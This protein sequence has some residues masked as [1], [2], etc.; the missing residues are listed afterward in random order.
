[1]LWPRGPLRVTDDFFYIYIAYFD[2]RPKW[3]P[4][5]QV[6]NTDMHHRSSQTIL[7][8]KQQN[9]SQVYRP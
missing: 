7:S 2:C 5:K 8:T 1:M 9:P 3:K 6:R 4:P